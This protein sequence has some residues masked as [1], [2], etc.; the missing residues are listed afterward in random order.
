[1]DTDLAPTEEMKGSIDN[2]PLNTPEMEKAFP[3]LKGAHQDSRKL[4]HERPE[5]NATQAAMRQAGVDM[6]LDNYLV[7]AYAGDP[8]E[9][10]KMDGEDIAMLPPEFQKEVRD[11]LAK[12]D[13]EKAATKKKSTK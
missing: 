9:I 2:A 1:M 6:N 5:D 8:P 3:E 11:Q 12:A 4:S 10:D 13:R 7:W